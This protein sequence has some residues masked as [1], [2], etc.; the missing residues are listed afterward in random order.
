MKSNTFVVVRL[1]CCL[2]LVLFAACQP[3]MNPVDVK[4][5]VQGLDGGNRAVQSDSRSSDALYYYSVARLVGMEGELSA[6]A[7]SLE[8]AISIDPDSAYLKITLA[9]IY[10]HLDEIEKSFRVA[11]DALIL[12]PDLLPGHLLLANLHAR[13]SRYPEAIFHLEKAAELDPE[14]TRILFQLALYH[15]R[16]GDLPK[17]IIILKKLVE[18]SPDDTP[19]LLALARAYRQSD[20]SLLAAEIYL[21]IIEQEPES[22]LAITE[23]AELYRDSGRNVEAERLYL[24]KIREF[25][26]NARLRHRLVSQYIDAERYDDA[27]AQLND[28]IDINARDSAAL[29]KAGLLNFDRKEWSTAAGHFE[30]LIAVDAE[31]DQAHYYLGIAREEEGLWQEALKSFEQVDPSSSV[32]ADALIHRAFN[33]NRLSRIENA[34]SLLE[35]NRQ[36]L[37]SRAEIFDYLSF[38]YAALDQLDEALAAIAAGLVQY[39]EDNTLLFRKIVLLEK[40]G[41]LDLADQAAREL[42]QLNPDHVN[43]LNFLAYSYAVRNVNLEQALTMVQKALSAKDEHYIRDTLGW[44]LYRLERY[45]E[46]LTQLRIAEKNAPDDPVVLEHLGFV[47]KALGRSDEALKAFLKAL[48]ASPDPS[49]ELQDEI[50]SLRRTIE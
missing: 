39:P 33:L 35:D 27:L 24:E 7:K 38:L 41:Q 48:N 17:S 6:A 3:A 34:I 12:D 22:F 30:Q 2:I 46:S 36:L 40:V 45:E 15:N 44:V 10:L 16:N 20:L 47:L 28:L 32:Y 42:L 29:R 26:E 4:D 21:E 49:Q 23:L 19:V 25:P 50:N 14:D 9:E 43:A 8:K 18:R 37:S 13:Q 11:E 1:V 5:G 31:D